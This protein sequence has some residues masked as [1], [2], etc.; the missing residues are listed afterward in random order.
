MVAYIV[1]MITGAVCMVMPLIY[2]MNVNVCV[3]TIMAGN[4]DFA[5]DRFT[6]YTPPWLLYAISL[7]GAVVLLASA[8][9]M[10]RAGSAQLRAK[11]PKPS[12]AEPAPEPSGEPDPPVTES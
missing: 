8:A 2:A 10:V 7:V 5:P 9:M 1:G 3:A 4:P 12:A 11:R 6:A